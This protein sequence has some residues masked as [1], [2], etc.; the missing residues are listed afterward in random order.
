MERIPGVWRPSTKRFLRGIPVDRNLKLCFLVQGDELPL[1]LW[2][3]A[4]LL[5]TS[6]HSKNATHP[7]PKSRQP[8]APSSH[9]NASP[10]RPC[11]R[12]PF[13]FIPKS[14]SKSSSRFILLS[15]GFELFLCVDYYVPVLVH[16]YVCTWSR[17]AYVRATSSHSGRTSHSHVTATSTP[18]TQPYFCAHAV[19]GGKIDS[20]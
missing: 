14:P 4:Q 12:N 2:Q 3:S 5:F 13:A 11:P 1:L 15:S 17:C 10:C 16:V 19:C 8:S 7:K 18:A 6:M 20:R 9:P